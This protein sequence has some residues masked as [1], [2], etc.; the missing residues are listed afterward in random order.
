MRAYL[1][2]IVLLIVLGLLIGSQYR[3]IADDPGLGWHIKTGNYIVEQL[4]VPYE[5]P[6]LYAQEQRSWISD[7]WLSDLLLYLIYLA[8]SWP[9]LYAVFTIIFLVTFFLIAPAYLKLYG[10]SLWSSIFSIIVCQRLASVHF[11]IRPV[12]FSFI[13]FLMLLYKLASIEKRPDKISGFL[14]LPLIFL[15]WANTHPSFVLGIFVYSVFLALRKPGAVLTI[16]FLLSCAATF[17]NPYAWRLHLSIISLSQSSFFMNLN[18][19]W[20]ALSITSPEGLLATV[21]FIFCVLIRIF[22]LKKL[23][24]LLLLI[25]FYCFS[26]YSIRFLPYFSL[27]ALLPFAISLDFVLKNRFSLEMRS[28]SAIPRA[29]FCFLSIVLLVCAVFF[30]KIPFYSGEYGPSREKF[31]YQAMNYLNNKLRQ[32]NGEI[33]VL[34]HPNWGGFI[35]LQSRSEGGRNFIKPLIDDRNTLLGENFYLEFFK[36]LSDFDK[37]VLYIGKSEAAYILLSRDSKLASLLKEHNNFKH[38]TEVMDSLLFKRITSTER[39]AF[40]SH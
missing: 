16:S 5:D 39:L 30:Q 35:A 21:V 28:F 36:N 40:S 1:L 22:Y 10:A 13:F 2:D 27:V 37:A 29:T 8:G 11:I 14:I 19:E 23:P 12:M 25:C 17:I 32:T 18:T 26:L 4:R 20:H 24:N 33:V 31:P 34:A 6:F 7:Q 3:N 38:L 9:L 15:L